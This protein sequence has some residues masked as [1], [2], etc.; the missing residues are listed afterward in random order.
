[1]DG[2]DAGFND[3]SNTYE[4][5]PIPQEQFQSPNQYDNNNQ[6]LIS[7]FCGAI[8][9]GDLTAAETALTLLGGGEIV[10]AAKILCGIQ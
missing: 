2:Y 7:S 4:P 6:D 10:L 9:R 1:M 5:K 8:N 3:C